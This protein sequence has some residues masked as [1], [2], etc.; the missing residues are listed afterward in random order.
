MPNDTQNVISIF[1][2]FAAFGLVLSMW[3]M[4][5]L[6]W[7]N[8]R[9]RRAA[10]MQGRL[11]YARDASNAAVGRVLRLWHDGKEETMLVPGIGPTGLIV[12]MERIRVAA[13]VEMPL[14][15]AL[16]ML[17]GILLLVIGLAFI[18]TSNLVIALLCAVGVVVVLWISLSQKIKKRTNTFERQFVDALELAARSLRAGHPLIGSFRLITE[19]IAAPVGTLFGEVCQQQAL[20]VSMEQALRNVADDHHSEDLQLFITSVVIQLASGGNL[21]EMME[22]LAN[23]I[24]DRQRLSRRVRVLT[25][26]TQFS[27]RVL[28][29]LPFLVFVV[30]N[31]INPQYMRPLYTTSLGQVIMLIASMGLLMGWITMNWLS[32][33]TY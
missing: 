16:P 14:S 3:L 13:G 7:V 23:V 31:L 5:V 6:L 26:Q 19:E 22:R 1:A 12:R 28:L 8:R 15:T 27:K 11:E 9:K 4:G 30:L 24:R 18:I 17:G 21:A 32:K 2:G 25:A 33:L 20:G 10:A 29:A